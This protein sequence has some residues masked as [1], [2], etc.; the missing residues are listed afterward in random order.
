MRQTASQRKILDEQVLLQLKIS[1]ESP[2]RSIASDLDDYTPL[3]RTSL[4][5]LVKQRRAVKRVA[6]KSRFA[7][8]SLN[9]YRA[10]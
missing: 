6:E 10:A 2:A 1:G 7:Q 9:L 8:H 3:V 5:R 4:E